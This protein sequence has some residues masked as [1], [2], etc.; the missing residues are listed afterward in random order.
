MSDNRTYN[1][2]DLRAKKLLDKRSLKSDNT[3]YSSI[4]EANLSIQYKSVGLDVWIND[5]SGLKRYYYDE[6]MSLVETEVNAT[7]E[8]GAKEW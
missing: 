7:M 3:P 5:G 6:T 4:E 2:F 8:W 1:S